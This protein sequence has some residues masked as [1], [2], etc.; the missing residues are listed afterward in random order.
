MQMVSDGRF[1][2][3]GIAHIA[4]SLT[5]SHRIP[6]RNL[7]VRAKTAVLG[8]IA[9]FVADHHGRS[10]R[11]ILVDG[12]N[13]AVCRRHHHRARLCGIVNAAVNAPV[14][15]GLVIAQ[16]IHCIIC[17]H[18][19]V[20]RLCDLAGQLP[21]CGFGSPIGSG[22]IAGLGGYCLYPVLD[23][24]A[25]GGCRVVL[26]TDIFICVSVIQIAG[27]PDGRSAQDQGYVIA[28]AAEAFDKFFLAHFKHLRS[29]YFHHFGY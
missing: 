8:H 15:G 5:G 3:G 18:I 10:H 19:T 26:H 6:G 27:N 13:L 24:S 22:D 28:L 1:Q 14:P 7:Q 29:H 12:I 2:Q 16:G 11:V 4:D 20:H 17:D 25:H 21:F 9:A 23:L